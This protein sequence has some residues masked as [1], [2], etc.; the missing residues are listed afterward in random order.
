[1]KILSESALSRALSLRDLTDPSQ[2][3]HAVQKVLAA[4]QGA[5][6]RAW[7]PEVRLE[8]RS[9]IVSVTDNYDALHYP[10]GGASRDARYTRHVSAGTVLRTQT[11]A[12]IPPTLRE[13]AARGQ[14][15]DVLLVCPGLVYRRDILDRLHVGE[16]HQVDLWRIRRDGPRLAVRDLAEMITRVADAVAPGRPVRVL[17]TDHPYTVEGRQVDVKVAGGWIEIGECGLALPELLRENGLPESASGLAMGLGLDRLVMIAKGLDDIR[18]LRHPDPRIAA[19]MVD[20]G[21]WRPVSNRPPVRRDLSLA[22]AGDA[23]AEALG[24]R[25][26]E[27]L[28]ERAQDV[29]AVEVL[30]ET[31]G[32]K[33]PEAARARL[34]LRDGQK[35][36]LLRV[37]LRAH[38]RTLTDDEANRLRDEVYAA[39]HEGTEWMWAAGPAAPAPAG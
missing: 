9:P 16:P 22:V 3:P 17:P 23:D 14:E 38:D 30:S 15:K 31:P 34:G 32:E 11:S 35:N 20:L 27:V 6:E 5:L 7:A 24:D 2:G 25:V 18:L 29:E 1:M 39:L 36:V 33:L 21:P 37:V 13:L 12:M 8:R 10:P 19:Q 28:A 26:R 4:A